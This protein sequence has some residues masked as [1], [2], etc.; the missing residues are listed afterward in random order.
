[1]RQKMTWKYYSNRRKIT[2][3]SFIKSYDVPMTYE[4]LES[5][6]NSMWVAAPTAEEFEKALN[7]VHHDEI[8]QAQKQR[9]E[10]SKP[11]KS[12]KP[13]AKSTSRRST[14]KT[15]STRRTTKKVS[16]NPD[17]LWD[18][19]QEGAYQTKSTVS[20]KKTSTRKT[21]TRKTS[22]KKGS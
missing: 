19:A 4:L 20:K 5:E 22:N 16:E 21:S 2:L 15:T 7:Q 1:M 17:E 18:D 6:L 8:I 9:P 13:A 12:Q 3:E 14:K 10:G 11:S